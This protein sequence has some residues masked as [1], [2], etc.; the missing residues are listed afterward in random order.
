MLK[1]SK[2]GINKVLQRKLKSKTW[3]DHLKMSEK[4]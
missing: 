1:L 3:K 2:F 4:A